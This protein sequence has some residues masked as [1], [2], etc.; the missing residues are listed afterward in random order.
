MTTHYCANC[1]NAVYRTRS[2]TWQHRMTGGP[3]CFDFTLSRRV[4]A[5]GGLMDE[6]IKIETKKMRDGSYRSR[7]FVSGEFYAEA[8]SR[9]Q[10]LARGRQITTPCR[11]SLTNG[12]TGERLHTYHGPD[13]CGIGPK[14][15]GSPEDAKR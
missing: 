3:T 1:G 6:R 2:G 4:Q 12:G 10:E 5:L 9:S 14:A 7:V 15:L 13:S 8:R 11:L